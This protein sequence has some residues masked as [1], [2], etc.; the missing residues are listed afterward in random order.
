MSA[1]LRKPVILILG[2]ITVVSDQK[3]FFAKT[4]LEKMIFFNEN[5]LCS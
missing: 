4:L 1:F 5:I 3:T 2:S